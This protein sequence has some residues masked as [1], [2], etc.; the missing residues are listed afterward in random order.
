MIN[1]HYVN[2]DDN[3]KVNIYDTNNDNNTKNNYNHC[4]IKNSKKQ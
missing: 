1:D 3:D 2:D 4:D